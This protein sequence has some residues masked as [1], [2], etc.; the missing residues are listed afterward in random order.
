[1]NV[2]ARNEYA[3]TCRTSTT[4]PRYLL[5]TLDDIAIKVQ[6]KDARDRRNLRLRLRRYD[7]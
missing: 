3:M 5:C 6:E 7:P 2:Y 1:M 4:A